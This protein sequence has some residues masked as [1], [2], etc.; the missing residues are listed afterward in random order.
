MKLL[1]TFI[2]GAAGATIFL[3]STRMPQFLSLTARE[4]WIFA[5]GATVGLLVG[6]GVLVWAFKDFR[7]F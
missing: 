1:A 3:A 2:A 4:T 5:I 7:L 6:L